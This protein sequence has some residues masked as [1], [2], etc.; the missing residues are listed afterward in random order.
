MQFPNK[1]QSNSTPLD[2]LNKK[3]DELS[4]DSSP[5]VPDTDEIPF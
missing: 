2:N 1:N 4:W 3:Q 5:L